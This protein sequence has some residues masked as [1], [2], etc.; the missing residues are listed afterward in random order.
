MLKSNQKRWMS[1]STYSLIRITFLGWLALF[2]ISPIQML[3]GIPI[4]FVFALAGMTYYFVLREFS[5]S[6][7]AWSQLPATAWLLYG[8]RYGTFDTANITFLKQTHISLQVLFALQFVGL[9]FW[10]V[11]VFRN[12]TVFPSASQ[13]L[14]ALYWPCLIAVA[15]SYSLIVYIKVILFNHYS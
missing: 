7:F 15:L 1:H 5:F 14:P 10:Q 8:L 3:V 11:V 4:F 9:V 12:D 2:V 13:K 6:N